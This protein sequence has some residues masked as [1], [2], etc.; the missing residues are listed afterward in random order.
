MKK[1]YS[2]LPVI[3]IFFLLGCSSS[4]P[5]DTNIPQ[6][7]EAIPVSLFPLQSS[8]MAATVTASGTFSTKDETLL[9]FK[10]GG[11]VAKV[12]VEEGDAVKSG[13][14]VA[15]L[16]LTEI[17]AGVRQ[18][19]LAYE[20]ALRDH[21]RAAR[22]Y[23]D[24]VATLEQFENSKTAVDIAEQ[25]LNT[26]NFNMAQSQIRATKNGFVLK[27]F[28]NPGQL[29]ASGTPILQINGAASG[30]W[31]LKVTLSDQQW[32]SIQIGDQAEINAA[33]T[34]NWTTAKVTHK[35]QS[36][37]PITG[38][39]W[40]EISPESI[41]EVSLASGMFGKARIQPSQTVQGWEIPFESVLDANGD[42]GFVFVV[43]GQKAKKVKVQLGKITPTSIQVVAG[44]ENYKSLIVSGSAYLSDGSTIQ[45]KN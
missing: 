28:V 18:S 37:D 16:D 23:T 17:Q 4:A 45:V 11:I 7:G 40:V 2:L 8:E 38:T 21:Q 29:V 22:L 13:Q 39:Y 42:D 14:I 5:S 1:R 27:K 41:K 9:S 30:A 32:S 10:L 35:S 31:I 24:S 44:L 43:D 6:A 15:S 20:K 12:L 25:Q 26:A 3:S 34:S 33:A 19:K 36:A